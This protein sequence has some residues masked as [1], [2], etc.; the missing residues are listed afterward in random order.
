MIILWVTHSGASYFESSDIDDCRAF[1]RQRKL[2]TAGCE[3]SSP[4]ARGWHSHSTAARGTIEYSGG[5]RW[6]AGYWEG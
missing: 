2:I 6:T 4:T 1:L 5:G 3:C